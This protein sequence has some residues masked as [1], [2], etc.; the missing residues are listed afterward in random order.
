MNKR[1]NQSD[2]KVRDKSYQGKDSIK[3][4]DDRKQAS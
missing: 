3:K 2:N 1:A 4:D